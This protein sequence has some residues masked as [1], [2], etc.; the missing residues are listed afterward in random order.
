MTI[1]NIVVPLEVDYLQAAAKERGISRTK[2]VRIVMERVVRD[3]LVSEIIGDDDLGKSE[4][5]TQKY[6]RFR[7]RSAYAPGGRAAKKP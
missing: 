7:D 4:P 1:K 6:R 5:S 2:L 3:E